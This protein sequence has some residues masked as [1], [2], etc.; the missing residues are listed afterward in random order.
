MDKIKLL[1]TGGNG[2]K[3]EHTYEDIEKM[4]HSNI[5]FPTKILDSVV[6]NKVKYFLNTGTFTEYLLDENQTNISSNI[7]PKNLYS[8][9]KVSFEQIL[10]FYI[11]NYH[12]NAITL[13][14][15]APYGY[16]DNPKKFI[17]YLINS[18]IK[19]EEAEVSDGYQKWD[20]VYV[21]DIA[22]AY[23]KGVEY[24]INDRKE[25][26]VFNI[27]S[28]ETHGLREIG[29]II[30]SINNNF[31]IKWGAKPYRKNEVFYAK[32]D[33][34]HSINTLG[35]QPEYNLKDGIYETYEKYKEELKNGR[36]IA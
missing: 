10:K 5:I 6:R 7:F 13:K 27:G 3:N 1:I 36:K 19:G 22:K 12:L 31:Q 29:E 34:T 33:I 20:Y 2:F 8:T 32:A 30:K 14:L 26:D 18:A 25:Y 28:G 4:L 17:P 16:G 24:L 23:L 9:S 15:F 21:K 35:W 11:G